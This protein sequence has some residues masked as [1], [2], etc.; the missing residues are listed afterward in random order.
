MH[1][2]TA[3]VVLLGLIALGLAITYRMLVVTVT[4]DVNVITG[5]FGLIGLLTLASAWVLEQH[6]RSQRRQR[7]H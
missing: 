7:L 4:F 6:L 5:G 2:R 1:L 3:L